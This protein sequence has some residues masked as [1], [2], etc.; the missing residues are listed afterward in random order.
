LE[1]GANPNPLLSKRSESPLERAAK[2]SQLE[3]IELL[4][5]HDAIK[6][7]TAL[8]NAQDQKREQAIINLLQP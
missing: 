4:L 8:K 3:S 1:N 6:T 5:K 2:Y 7:D